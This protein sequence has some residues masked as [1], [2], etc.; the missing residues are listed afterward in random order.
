M[1]IFIYIVIV[2]LCLEG[3]FAMARQH[4]SASDTAYANSFDNYYDPEE[5]YKFGQRIIKLVRNEDLRGLFAL[6]DGELRTGPRKWII[7]GHQFRDVFPKTWKT[8]LIKSIPPCSP[9]GGRG[10]MLGDG[11]IWFDKKNQ[12]KTG[13][14]QIFSINGARPK[15]AKIVEFFEQKQRLGKTYNTHS[16][17]REQKHDLTREEKRALLKEQKQSL[18]RPQDY[19]L[20]RK[21]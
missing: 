17:P 5:A 4:C 12:Q 14:W 15:T 11:E 7:K 16:L 19:W 8:K 6:V 9:V 2:T 13:K 21:S 20:K 3:S 10:F 18:A 1:K